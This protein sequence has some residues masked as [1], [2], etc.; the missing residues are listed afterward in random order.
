MDNPLAV[1][2]GYGFKCLFEDVF[3]LLL[4]D[5]SSFEFG[6]KVSPFKVAS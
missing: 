1:A 3:G 5:G 4:A 6:Q 2:I